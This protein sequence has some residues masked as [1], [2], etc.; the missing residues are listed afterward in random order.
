[1]FWLSQT[2]IGLWYLKNNKFVQNVGYEIYRYFVFF[3]GFEGK[4][5]N[6]IANGGDECEIF[7]NNQNESHILSEA[8]TE[9]GVAI[10]GQLQPAGKKRALF[11]GIFGIYRASIKH[12]DSGL[13][14]YLQTSAEYHFS[15]GTCR[16]YIQRAYKILEWWNRFRADVVLFEKSP[17]R[18]E[19][20]I[21]GRETKKWRY[22]HHLSQGLQRFKLGP[23]VYVKKTVQLRWMKNAIKPFLYSFTLVFEWWSEVQPFQGPGNGFWSSL[24]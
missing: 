16:V 13:A 6:T 21:M 19:L 22:S 11:M 20:I 23:S 4:I 8:S 5:T 2:L 9:P 10:G 1:M 24:G 18:Y 17:G 7:Y 12:V 14:G 3:F 15:A